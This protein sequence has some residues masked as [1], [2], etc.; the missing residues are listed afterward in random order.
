[1]FFEELLSVFLPT[2]AISALRRTATAPV[3]GLSLGVL[4]AGAATI[5]TKPTTAGI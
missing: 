4:V 2:I 1:M 3:I 5:I